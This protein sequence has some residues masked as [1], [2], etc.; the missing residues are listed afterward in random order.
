MLDLAENDKALFVQL[1]M[2][3]I[4]NDVKVQVEHTVDLGELLAALGEN[5]LA[6]A[7]GEV[8]THLDRG[9]RAEEGYQDGALEVTGEIDDV[10]GGAITADQADAVAAFDA[11]GTEPGAAPAYAVGQLTGTDGDKAV[12]SAR[13]EEIGAR[14]LF[15]LVKKI[16]ERV[17]DSG[18]K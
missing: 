12:S 6:A 10:P 9:K 2:K 8:V 5:D 1:V 13:H 17:H 15:E 4:P 16:C 14:F 18:G 11:E 3:T 7:V